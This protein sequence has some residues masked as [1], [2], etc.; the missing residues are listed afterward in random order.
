MPYRRN[1]R[2]KRPRRKPRRI[3][4]R[5]QARS[6]KVT[7]LRLRSM[8]GFPDMM[9]VPLKYV[10]TI[11]FSGTNFANHEFSGNKP[12][13]PNNTGSGH[14]PMYWDEYTVLYN[15]WL[16]YSCSIRLEM[17]NSSTAATNVCLLPAVALFPV[18][19][20]SK[21]QEQP[22][23]R[24]V[25]VG[26]F[27]T[28]RA[29]LRHNMSTR[30]IRGETVMDDEFSGQGNLGNP[31]RQ[32]FWGIVMQTVPQSILLN[33]V[34]KFTLVYQIRFFKRNVQEQS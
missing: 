30:K 15:R 29:T 19:D 14:Q 5:R 28:N 20:V 32:W 24:H 26:N 4:R 10:E 6:N 31:Q 27:G 34:I 16:A 17:I 25:L 22:H 11:E 13:D 1:Y 12:S 3:M 23:A 21:V 8:T 9:Y 7:S 33:L 2:K 18:L